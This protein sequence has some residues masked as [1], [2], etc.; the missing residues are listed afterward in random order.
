[1][2]VV[3]AHHHINV[4]GLLGDQFLILLSKTS[5]H[6]DLAAVLLALPRLQV[7]QVAIQLVVGVLSDAAR[8]EHHDIGI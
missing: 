6:D 7:A 3:R 5:C 2:N 8:V 1:M 4:A